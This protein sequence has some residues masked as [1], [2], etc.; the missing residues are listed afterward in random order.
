MEK[1]DEE[2]GDG[3]RPEISGGLQ[4]QRTSQSFFVVV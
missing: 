3:S 1:A 4:E 2:A